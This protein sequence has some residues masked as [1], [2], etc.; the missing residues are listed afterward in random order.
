MSTPP[1][2]PPNKWFWFKKDGMTGDEVGQQLNMA[3]AN[4]Y[5]G[6]TFESECADGD[7]VFVGGYGET[8]SS[9]APR[10]KTK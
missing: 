4:G 6:Q 2:P 5:R 1:Q 8:F 7:F 3:A 9:A 10:L